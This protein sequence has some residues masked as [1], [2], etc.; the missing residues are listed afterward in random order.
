M[1][2]FALFPLCPK[3]EVQYWQLCMK[4]SRPFVMN[5]R[6]AAVKCA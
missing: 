5:I 3:M 2:N 1:L 4:I 6:S